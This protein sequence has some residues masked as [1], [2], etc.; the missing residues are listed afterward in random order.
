MQR[1]SFLEIQDQPFK[2]QYQVSTKTEGKREREREIVRKGISFAPV[3]CKINVLPHIV[4][5]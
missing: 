4:A 2:K 5:F 1:Y 3:F